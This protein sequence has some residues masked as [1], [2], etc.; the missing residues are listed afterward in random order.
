MGTVGHPTTAPLRSSPRLHAAGRSPTRA[1]KFTGADR[2]T[3]QE[4]VA[5]P[6]WSGHKGGATPPLSGLGAIG[7][8]Q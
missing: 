7:C 6:E 4:L 1:S 3:R 2:V 5:W 8:A